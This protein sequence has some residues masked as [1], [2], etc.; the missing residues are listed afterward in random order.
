M[1]F[2]LNIANLLNNDTLLQKGQKLFL[3]GNVLVS[4]DPLINHWYNYG[5]KDNG[6]V[7]EV[8]AP[9]I[10]LLDASYC[11]IEYFKLA[12][13]SCEYYA[14]M[15]Y[16]HHICA[17]LSHLDNK[18]KSNNVET[19][20]NPS[21]W[22]SLML[23]EKSTVINQYKFNL[24]NFFEYNWD[25]RDITK[26]LGSLAKDLKKYPELTSILREQLQLAS[27]EFINEK[28]IIKLFIHSY[29]SSQNSL[30]WFL[31]FKPYLSKIH[32][33]Y[34]VELG[35]KIYLNLY[36]GLYLSNSHN[37]IIK[38]LQN[39]DADKKRQISQELILNYI[40]QP[41]I[42]TDFAIK[43]QDKVTL[44]DNLDSFDPLTLLTIGGLYPYEHDL[45]ENKVY[46]QIKV[47]V[48]FLVSTDYTELLTVI[49]K[50]Y[51]VFGKT[52]KFIDMIDYISQTH[53]KKKSLLK[54]LDVY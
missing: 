30:E 20:V 15:G 54:E 52:E 51:L 1:S 35:V 12:H 10:H 32:D 5:V 16:C 37:E 2:Y 42:W 4:K 33:M 14:H 41:K 47:W 21:L 3:D 8:I 17:V 9:T 18:Y 11:N 22:D 45:I 7:I 49:E 43:A 50:W 27:K 31:I 19:K 23:G 48:D 29:L 36:S 26:N 53:P 38:F 25:D 24:K 34:L 6:N 46:N 39:F 44:L 13:C 28:K 40:K